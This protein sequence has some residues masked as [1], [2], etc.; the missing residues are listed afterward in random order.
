MNPWWLRPPADDSSNLEPDRNSRKSASSQKQ[1]KGV[2]GKQSETSSNDNDRGSRVARSN[3]RPKASSSRKAAPAKKTERRDRR[4]GLF[5]DIEDIALG[6]RE[7]GSKDFDVGLVLKG[8]LEQGSLVV[9]RAYADWGRFRDLKHRYHEAGFELIDVPR[10]YHSGKS[11]CNIKLA[12]DAIDLCYSK[13]H[14]DTFAILSGDADLCPLVSK[15]R[16]NGKRVVGIGI[17]GSASKNLIESCDRYLFPQDLAPKMANQDFPGDL[18]AQRIEAFSIVVEAVR[19]L[20]GE[21]R[22]RIWGSMIKQTIQRN[23]PSFSEGVYGYST[24]SDLLEDAQTCNIIRLE[25][26]DRSGSYVVTDFREL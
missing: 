19:S 3:G 24:F 2:A 20:M 4:I 17:E 23:Q 14:V 9:R 12:V 22:D 16:E 5:C 6:L 11:S 25:R 10:K 13:H 18:S 21:N 7:T 1:S 8:L 26:D 15:L